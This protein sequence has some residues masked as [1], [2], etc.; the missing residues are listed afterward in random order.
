MKESKK[1]KKKKKCKEKTS[2]NM[3]FCGSVKPMT[4]VYTHI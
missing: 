4:G 3:A 2:A 1:E